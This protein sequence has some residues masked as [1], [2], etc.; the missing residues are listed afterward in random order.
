MKIQ[1]FIVLSNTSKKN[2]IVYLGNK[3]VDNRSIYYRK[4]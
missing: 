4:K 2:Q 1:G 3:C